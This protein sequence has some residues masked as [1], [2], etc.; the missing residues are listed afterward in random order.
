M[1]SSLIN[2]LLLT[3]PSL[4]NAPPQDCPSCGWLSVGI[5][6]KRFGYC[7]GTGL[8]RGY[9]ALKGSDW[10][11]ADRGGRPGDPETRSTRPIGVVQTLGGNRGETAG[12][13][14]VNGLFVF[15]GVRFKG[16]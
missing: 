9:G 11:L 10:M 1:A 2:P 13:T 7:G 4:P 15:S 14:L 8:V 16:S 3:P 12:D 6:G 5:E